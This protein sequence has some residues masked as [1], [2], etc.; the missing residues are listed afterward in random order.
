MQ[1]KLSIITVNLN[2]AEGLIKAIEIIA[3]QIFTGNYK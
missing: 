3:K 2:N 1:P